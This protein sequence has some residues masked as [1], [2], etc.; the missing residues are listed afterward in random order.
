MELIVI[1][2][3]T[4]VSSEAENINRL[5]EAGLGVFHLRKPNSDL[6]SMH[7][8][9]SHIDPKYHDQIAIHQHHDLAAEFGLKR[10]HFTETERNKTQISELL[11]IKD[12]GMKIS[13]SIHDISAL[14]ELS[15]FDY[16]FFSPVF[17]S[18]S[19]EGYKSSVS[20][21][22]VV[23]KPKNSPKVI[24]LG[25]IHLGNIDLVK[26]MNFD[27]AAV[28]GSIWNKEESERIY[29]LKKLLRKSSKQ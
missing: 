9:I 13:T 19:K 17:D 24:A 18:I 6:E 23:E 26:S 15:H 20:A 22:F 4:P 28:L 2:S 5:F 14:N 27:G 21:D 7:Q 8:L 1:S 10:L 11:K 25:G 3:P 16:T 29:I 12:R